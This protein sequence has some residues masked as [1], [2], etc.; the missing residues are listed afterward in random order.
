MQSYHIMIAYYMYAQQYNA[1][2]THKDRL[3]IFLKQ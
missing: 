1:A 3:G 2:C